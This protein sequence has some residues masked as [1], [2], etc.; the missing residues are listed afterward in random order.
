MPQYLKI[1]LIYLAAVGVF[2]VIITV[3]DKVCAKNGA[4][5]IPE[6]TLMG[7]GF[8]GGA[9]PMFIT[10]KLIR[11]KT[12]HKKFMLGLPA[13]I[14]LHAVICVAAIYIYTK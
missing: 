1:I 7:I 13:E 11:H 4:L 9:L 10:M 14:V 5:R 8:I 2:S 6:A 3:Y 12:K